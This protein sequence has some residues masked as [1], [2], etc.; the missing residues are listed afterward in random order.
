MPRQHGGPN[1]LQATHSDP[2]ANMF[3]TKLLSY[4]SPQPHG[5]QGADNF[6]KIPTLIKKKNVARP[7]KWQLNALYIL[8]ASLVHGD[9]VFPQVPDDVLA[10]GQGRH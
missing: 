3:P 9:R 4:H 6:L 1:R 7:V 10:E 2:P 5:L 8:V